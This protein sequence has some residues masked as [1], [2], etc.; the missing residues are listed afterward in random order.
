[1]WSDHSDAFAQEVEALEAQADRW[2]AFK[3]AFDRWIGCRCDVQFC[4]HYDIAMRIMDEKENEK[5]DGT[6]A[7]IVLFKRSTPEARVRTLRALI[8]EFGDCQTV[9]VGEHETI[10]HVIESKEH[11][12]YCYLDQP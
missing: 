1:M 6:D 9:R 2:K 11:K 8:A 12:L 4:H 3:R 5:V 10:A 7:V